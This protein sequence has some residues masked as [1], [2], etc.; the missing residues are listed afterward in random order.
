MWQRLWLRAPP[1]LGKRFALCPSPL[2]PITRLQRG[3]PYSSSPIRPPRLFAGVAA[4]ASLRER[5][6]VLAS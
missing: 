3:S 1:W 5:A 4:W 2:E 6:C